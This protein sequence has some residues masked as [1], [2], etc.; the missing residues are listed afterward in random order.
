[1]Q[2]VRSSLKYRVE[3]RGDGGPCF[4]ADAGISCTAARQS[5]RII[6]R[7]L[8]QGRS[9]EDISQNDRTKSQCPT[10]M[11]NAQRASAAGN[12]EPVNP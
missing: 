3:G 4:L 12:S 7:H 6:S 1:M 9:Y 10:V 11:K 8:I 2:V 5:G